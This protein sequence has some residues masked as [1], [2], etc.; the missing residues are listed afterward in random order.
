[1]RRNT[2]PSPIW[3]AFKR[4]LLIVLTLGLLAYLGYQMLLYLQARRFLPEWTVIADVPVG[5]LSL[6]E[7]GERVTAMYMAPV[8]LLHRSEALELNPVDVGFTL[9]VDTM[10]AEA[11]R[12]RTSQEFWRGYLFHVI[13]WTWEP[14][15]VPLRA[16][17]DAARLQQMIEIV[18]GWLDEPATGPQILSERSAFR[19][20]EAGFVTNVET[21]LPLVEA[22]LYRPEERTVPLAVEEQEAGALTFAVLEDVIRGQLEQFDGLGIVYVQDLQTGE[23]IMINSDAAI[24]GTSVLKIAI[25]MEAYRALDNPPNDYVEG[26]FYDTAAKSSNF[27]A[28]LLLHVVAGEDNTY[29]GADILTE[30]VRRLGLVNTFMAVPYDA[31][32]PPHRPFT[33]ATEANS[34]PDAT[35]DIDPTMQTTAEEIGSLLSMIYYCSKG[36]GTLLAVY[37]DQITPEECQSIIDLMVLNEEGNLIRYGVPDGTPVSH[38]HGWARGTHADAGIVLSPGGAYVLVEYLHRPGSWLQA[39]ESFPIL[40]EISRAVYN[41]FNFGDPYL[42]DPLREADRIEEPFPIPEVAEEESEPAVIDRTDLPADD[43]PTP[44]AT[45]PAAASTPTATPATSAP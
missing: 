5:G 6:E 32:A 39:D 44:A 22:A 23:E 10:L 26:L 12:F 34:R 18:A 7:A 21:S 28:N 17:H 43:I 4:T 9:D 45:E 14:M 19:Q 16:S 24:S 41:Y 37:P 42:G 40:R 29:R 35:E 20:G 33:Y 2:G 3:T 1:L 13:G 8:I 36:G 31:A 15:E 27:G 25:F 11:E 38:K 30:S